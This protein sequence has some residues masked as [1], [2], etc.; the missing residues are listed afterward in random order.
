MPSTKIQLINGG[1]FDYDDIPNN[2]INLDDIAWS[3]SMQCRFAGHL[4]Q[5]YSVAQHCVTVSDFVSL[6]NPE[7]ALEGL[8]HDA[9]E[10]Y[11]VDVPSPL[12]HKQELSG[13]REIENQVHA[14]I[15]QVFNLQFPLPTCVIAADKLALLAE[16]Q[17]FRS[18]VF[19]EDVW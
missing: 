3:L 2:K 16:F 9:S 17:S 4:K 5:F 15:F 11:V 6:T 14:K 1:S 13:Y 8:L 18:G 19:R 12:K 10:A 7:F